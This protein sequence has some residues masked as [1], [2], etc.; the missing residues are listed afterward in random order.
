V[1]SRLGCWGAVV[2]SFSVLGY[3]TKDLGRSDATLSWSTRSARHFRY[4]IE[5]F[6]TGD[7]VSEYRVVACWDDVIDSKFRGLEL[8]ASFI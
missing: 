8:G 1:P 6:A 4:L 3:I 5:P 7:T 2:H